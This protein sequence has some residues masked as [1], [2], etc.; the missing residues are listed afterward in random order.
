MLPQIVEVVKTVH[1][2]AEVQALGVAKD[3]S[4][5]VHTKEY[6]GITQDLR[7]ELSTLLG[8]FKSKVRSQPD[9]KVLIDNMEK[10]LVILDKW[11]K[12]PKIIEVSKEVEV[13]V[14][15]DRPVLIPTKDSEK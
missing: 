11:I 1:E 8:S 14:E 15:K 7:G 13:T 9:L 10:Y 2:I 6:V 5:E 12:F 4:S 3:V